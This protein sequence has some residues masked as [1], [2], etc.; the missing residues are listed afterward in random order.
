MGVL[1]FRLFPEDVQDRVMVTVATISKD[2]AVK[3]SRIYPVARTSQAQVIVAEYSPTKVFA[4]KFFAEEAISEGDLAQVAEVIRTYDTVRPLMSQ[5]QTRV[6]VT[7][8]QFP[9]AQFSEEDTSHVSQ[10]NLN[11][12]RVIMPTSLFTNPLYPG[13]GQSASSH[14]L[15]HTLFWDLNSDVV[16]GEQLNADFIMKYYSLRPGVVKRIE[17]AQ[18]PLF[19]MFTESFYIPGACKCTT[20]TKD[21]H[22]FYNSSEMFASG[23]NC[24]RLYPDLFLQSYGQLSKQD[25]QNAQAV[26]ER[27][28]RMLY[29][30]QKDSIDRGVS[31]SIDR[32]K[33]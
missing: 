33:P 8:D 7:A 21:G 4:T 15:A 25:R 20:T 19:Q 24:I 6:Y 30:M 2:G 28:Y 5:R 13:D 1:S 31:T 11:R 16:N 12:Y 9:E 22:P 23:L 17:L 3:S 14:E 10:L 27:M 29:A 26:V 18:D 32:K